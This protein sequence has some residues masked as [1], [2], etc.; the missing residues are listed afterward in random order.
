MMTVILTVGNKRGIYQ[1]S[2]FQLTEDGTGK[3]I[4]DEPGSK[5]LDSEYLALY[6]KLSLTGVASIGGRKTIYWLADEMKKLEQITNINVICEA[7]VQWGN[8]KLGSGRNKHGLLLVLAVGEVDR[9]F[10]VA[11]IANVDPETWAPRKEF[12][13]T[14]RTTDKPFYLVRG[15]GA[16]SISDDEKRRLDALSLDTTK[17]PKQILDELAEINKDIGARSNGKV[18]AGCWV[19]SLYKDEADVVSSIRKMAWNSG[20]K[21][22]NVPQIRNQ[23]DILESAQKHLPQ[24][25][26]SKAKLVQTAGGAFGRW[27]KKTTCS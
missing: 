15:F 11:E 25:D 21:E 12:E 2:D 10:R 14:I 22:G 5:Q 7:L 16:D 17:S 24:F 4:S 26:F 8:T 9:P 18:S 20:G 23:Q 13:R 27:P 3:F 1:S 19:G 6:V